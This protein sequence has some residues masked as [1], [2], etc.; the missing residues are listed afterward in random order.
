M[1]IKIILIVAAVVLALFIAL[2]I[3]SFEYMSVAELKRQA[4]RGNPDAKLVYPVKAYGI[5]LWIVLWALQGIMTSGIVLLLHSLVGS[6]W[7]II[8]TIPLVLVMHA[9]LPWSRWPKP[10]LHLAA[11]V[12]PAIERVLRFLYPVLHL[13]QRAVGQWIQ[14]EPILLIQSKDELLEILRHNAEEFDHVNPEELR[15]AENAL[16]FGDKLIGNCM[17]PLDKITFIK[18]EETLTPVVLGELH[19]SGHSR[20]PV[21][22]G[23]NQNIIGTLY[24]KDAMQIKSSKTVGDV[25]RPE[26]YFINERQ[27]LDHALK[28]F[29]KVR[30]HMFIVVNEFEDV[31]GV[32][33][34]EDVLEEIIGH[35]IMDEF[36]QFD[37][38]KAVAKHH[39]KSKD[40][41]PTAVNL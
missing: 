5:Q 16:E 20:F 8:I 13:A 24:L 38:L 11:I 19:N 28:A 25:M 22:R 27:T 26:V 33:A 36:D 34:M 39:G 17:T 30:H 6:L 31:V 9:I 2:L 23:S 40:K 18:A 21:F 3:R 32:L 29:L 10:D 1:V 41:T 4:H 7:T 35:Q 12:S 37:D 14:P 15:I